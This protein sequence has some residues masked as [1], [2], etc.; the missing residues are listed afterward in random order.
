MRV[1]FLPL[2]QIAA[3]NK[4]QNA[5]YFIEKRALFGCFP[6]QRDVDDLHKIGVR[7][8][9]NLTR[10]D[11]SRI[12]PYK[13]RQDCTKITFPIKDHG[14]PHDWDELSV[15]ITQISNIIS[16]LSSAHKMYIHCRGG[17]GRAGMI[18]A[19]LLCHIFNMEPI[20]ALKKTSVFHAKRPNI[21]EKWKAIG[22]PH[23]Y[24]QRAFVYR[25]FEPLTLHRIQYKQEY[26]NGFSRF[27]A[28]PVVFDGRTFQ[29]LEGA[30]LFAATKTS[31]SA[32]FEKLVGK[33]AY[34]ARKTCFTKPCQKW[35]KKRCS[36]LEKLFHLKLEQHPS[37]KE[38]L[39]RSGFRKI[40]MVARGNFTWPAGDGINVTGLVLMKIRSHFYRGKKMRKL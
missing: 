2:N 30:L 10:P 18:V 23:E 31:I 28:H 29:C 25:F 11:E 3:H 5:S 9:V 39:L 12:L 1:N 33:S 22:S 14:V 19:I 15:F 36:V 7:Y 34:L 24:R 27:S 17:H 6:T 37:I 32:D 4:M 16:R 20:D 13:V 8:F 38:K 40:T 21:K 35:K 26:D